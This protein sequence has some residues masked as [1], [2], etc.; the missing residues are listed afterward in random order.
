MYDSQ[1]PKVVITKGGVAPIWIPGPMRGPPVV[2]SLHASTLGRVQ[3]QA[4][5][6]GVRG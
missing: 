2:E 5:V 1:L 3:A 6:D 4:I